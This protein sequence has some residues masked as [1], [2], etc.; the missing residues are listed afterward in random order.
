MSLRNSAERWGP[1]SQLLHWLIVVLLL[2]LSTVGLLLDSLPVSPKYFWVFDLHKSTGLTLLA[3]VLLRLGWR[4]YAGAP[5]PLP[6][7][8]T[9]QSR[10]AGATHGLLYL[11][12]WMLLAL[13]IAH[14]GAA[15]YHH[16]FLNDAT[17]RR[18]LPRRGRTPAP[19]KHD[20]P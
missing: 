2:V 6:G 16:L 8:P 12:I 11:L 13:G 1:V 5:R 18:M 15:F 17:L 10:L 9:W 19:E 3:L 4:L 7:T 14:V 20:A